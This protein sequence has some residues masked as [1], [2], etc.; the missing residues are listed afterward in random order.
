VVLAVLAIL[1]LIVILNITGVKNKGQTA[2]CDTDVKTVQSA[3]S[4]YVVDHGTAGLAAGPIAS[5]EWDL[6]VPAYIHTQPTSC[7]TGFSLAEAG[8][9]FTVSGS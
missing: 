9:S 5:S 6:I 1:A 4:A 8:S 3:I 2:S 7:L